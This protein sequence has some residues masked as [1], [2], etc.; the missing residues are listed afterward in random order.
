VVGVSKCV[1]VLS[2]GPD[3]VTTAYWAKAQGYEVHA[4]TFS[5]AQKAQVEIK[6]A[7]LLAARL[8]VG[9]LVVD[10]SPLRAVYQ[11]VTSLVDEDIEVT[12]EFT[13][14]IIV[15]FRNGVFLSVAVAYAE[16]IG[17]SHIFYGAHASDEPFY[18]DCRRE[19]YKAFEEATRLG[20]D[21]EI[22]IEAPFSDIPKSEVIKK[23]IELKVPLEQT[24]SC[25]LSGPLHCGRCESCL[26]RMKAFREAGVSDPTQYSTK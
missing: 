1:V 24:W 26:N 4:I 14:P 8:G 19:F 7:R 16:S 12:S 22:T 13:K 6:R 20:T 3:S 23:A 18:P 21:H 25:Y 15:P 10:L 2:G 5:Y 9:H 11:G 17:A